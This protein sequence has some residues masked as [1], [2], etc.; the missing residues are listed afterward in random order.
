VAVTATVSSNEDKNMTNVR[1][2]I[3]ASLL[4]LFAA[5]PAFAQQGA[6]GGSVYKDPQSRSYVQPASQPQADAAKAPGV[7]GSAPA[8]AG[9][10]SG[11][12]ASPPTDGSLMGPRFGGG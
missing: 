6:P 12:G 4:T 9:A 10:A 1:S 11:E 8:P 3:G 5:A 2:L 7:N